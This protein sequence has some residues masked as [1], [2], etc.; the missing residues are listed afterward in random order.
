MKVQKREKKGGT[1]P[2][3][4]KRNN[5]RAIFSFAFSFPKEKSGQRVCSK[6]PTKQITST[7]C[8]RDY[9]CNPERQLLF[10]LFFIQIEFFSF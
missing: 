9:K 7:T 1:L 6:S 5:T 2:G 3:R 8:G 4:I 10:F